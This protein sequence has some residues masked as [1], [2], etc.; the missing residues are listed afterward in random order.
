MHSTDT[1]GLAR[2]SDPAFAPCATKQG[3]T[4][5]SRSTLR[6]DQIKRK[7]IVSATCH[8]VIGWNLFIDD[9]EIEFEQTLAQSDLNVQYI[10]WCAK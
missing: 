7:L 3:V 8:H 6:E 4:R 5:I 10:A 1:T 2:I 9:V